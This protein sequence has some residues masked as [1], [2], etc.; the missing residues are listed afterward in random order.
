LRNSNAVQTG[1]GSDLNNWPNQAFKAFGDVA[2]SEQVRVHADAQFLWDYRGS[3]DGLAGLEKAIQGDSLE[4]RVEESL[5][6]VR[7]EGVFG[8]DT[9]VNV[10]LR[11]RPLPNL[12]AGLF[13]LNL[14]GEGGNHRMAYD[15]G[16][17]RPS[18]H[19]IRFI[20]EERAAGLTLGYSL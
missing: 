9:R 12:E 13:I 5:R 15:E 14:L 8:L 1:Y 4:S 6:K 2:L 17:S 3:L 18:P 11:W 10:S 16:N 7:E 20:R 19:R